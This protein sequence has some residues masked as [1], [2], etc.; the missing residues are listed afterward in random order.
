MNTYMNKMNKNNL[1]SQCR[2]VTIVL[3]LALKLEA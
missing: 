2:W 1:V 3:F